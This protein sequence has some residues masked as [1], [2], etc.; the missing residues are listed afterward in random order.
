MSGKL[1][2][3]MENSEISAKIGG[4]PPDSG[5]IRCGKYR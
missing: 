4:F 3:P 1:V 2:L 5:K